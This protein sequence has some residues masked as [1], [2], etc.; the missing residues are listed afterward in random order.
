[1]AN[2]NY[3]IAKWITQKFN[4]NLDFTIIDNTHKSL[5]YFL[6]ENGC[7]DSEMFGWFIDKGFHTNN[8]AQIVNTI[9][10]NR[11]MTPFMVMIQELNNC[12]SHRNL[13]I[14]VRLLSNA[15]NWKM[16]V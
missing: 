11:G 4:S 7:N 1:M 5:L 9:N 10:T 8:M 2:T 16:R 6:C 12:H 3:T 15:I 14:F 13:S